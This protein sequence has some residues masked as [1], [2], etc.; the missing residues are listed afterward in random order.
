MRR[1]IPLIIIILSTLLMSCSI[2]KEVEIGKLSNFR[3][4]GMAN[5]A[6]KCSA[7]IQI[8]NNSMFTYNLETSELHVFAG[9]NDFGIVKLPNEVKILSNSNKTYTIDIEVA[10][11][12]SEVGIISVINNIMGKKTKYSLRGNI[13]ARSYIFY[14]T[15]KVNETIGEW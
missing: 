3:M 8:S 12:D 14:K 1:I 15:L 6:I 11:N 7:D 5:N 13:K 9:E 10:I 4:K 2:D